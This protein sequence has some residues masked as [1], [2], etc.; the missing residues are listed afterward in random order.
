MKKIIVLIGVAMFLTM[1]LT[2]MA[3]ISGD[4]SNCHTMHNSKAGANMALDD[5]G[6]LTDIPNPVLLIGSC[7]GCH[8]SGGVLN[9][10]SF[11]GSD[12]PQVFH[13]NAVD[14]AGGNFAY[15]DG[16]KGGAA[17]DRKGHNVIDILAADGLLTYPPGMGQGATSALMHDE[18]AVP[19]ATFTCA[20]NDGCHGVRNQ[21]AAEAIAVPETPAV[22]LQ[23]MS[24][25]TGAHHYNIDGQIDGIVVGAD[26]DEVYNSYR[27]L[28]GVYG[29]EAADWM[30]TDVSNHNEYY[31]TN[32]SPFTDNNCNQCHE[33][34]SNASLTSSMTTPSN[35][36][37]GF[38]STCHGTFH[39]DTDAAGS[40]IRHPTDLTLPSTGEYAAYTTYNLTAPVARQTVPAAAS[41][42]VTPGTDLVMC[43]SCHVAHGSDYAGML[44][45]DYTTM[46][47]G[48]VTN[49]DTGCF[50]CHST[51]DTGTPMP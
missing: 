37:S 31:G 34:G 14:L 40:F 30:N 33:G 41:S 42:T 48:G 44:R 46:V 17:D 22:K 12:V 7:V 4:C 5:A 36:I 39:E 13:T 35:S 32:G 21:L 23:G 3:K 49:I 18:D 38:C 28:K 9:T 24:A 20:G 50:A 27:F 11:S 19:A 15:I 10:I 8:A 45:F 29:L 51:K 25:M 2:A 26:A 43:L 16:T 1:P 47:A 6:V